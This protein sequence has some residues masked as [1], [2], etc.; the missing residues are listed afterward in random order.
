MEEQGALRRTIPSLL[1][2]AT[3]PLR[4]GQAPFTDPVG[5][6]AGDANL[7]VVRVRPELRLLAGC[8]PGWR[9]CR[10]PHPHPP[11]PT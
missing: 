9:L 4:G 7:P 8:C 5:G 10:D 3:G 2:W 11:P 6:G 1:G